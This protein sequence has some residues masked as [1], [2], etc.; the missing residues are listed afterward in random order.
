MEVGGWVQVSLGMFFF[1]NRTKIALKL[2]Q[3]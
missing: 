1:Y 2:N 3:W